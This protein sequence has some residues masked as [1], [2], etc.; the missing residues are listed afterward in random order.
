MVKCTAAILLSYG[1]LISLR[2]T[3]DLASVRMSVSPLDDEED[4]NYLI[5]NI[6][7]WKSEVKMNYQINVAFATGLRKYNVIMHAIRY[8]KETAK[9]RIENK[10]RFSRNMRKQPG[11]SKKNQLI[12]TDLG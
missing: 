7:K 6:P 12:T 5:V 10:G 11:V 1:G 8:S 4:L 3:K 9:Q 2:E